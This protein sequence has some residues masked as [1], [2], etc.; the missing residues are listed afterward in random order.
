MNTKT[1][2]ISAIAAILVFSVALTSELSPAKAEKDSPDFEAKLQG[3]Q[4]TVPTEKGTGHG[5]AQFWFTDD[6]DALVY[7]IEVSK[8][9]IVTWNGQTSKG[10]GGDTITKIHLHNN[11]PGEAGPHVLNIFGAPSEDDGDLFVD[12]NK[13]TFAGTWDDGDANDLAPPGRSPN[14]SVKFT[15]VDPLSG[16]TPKDELCAGNLYVNIHSGEHGPGALRGQIIPSST[17][18]E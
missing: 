10:S 14:D 17:A 6:K 11:E 9:Y 3:F 15:Q 8:N 7:E 2:T 4:Q 18:C 16:N 13:R 12:V 1:I 5:K